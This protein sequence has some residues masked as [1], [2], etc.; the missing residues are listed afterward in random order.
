MKRNI[1]KVEADTADAEKKI[2]A[3]RSGLILLE[4]PKAPELAKAGEA[5]PV[6]AA[7]A[8]EMV[9]LRAFTSSQTDPEA[10]A[11][12]VPF[13]VRNKMTAADL[14]RR[15]LAA[16]YEPPAVAAREVKVEQPK[17]RK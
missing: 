11:R 9:A 5:Y 13:V 4:E 16:V 2:E 12:G 10:L 3:V 1:P 15:G 8:I 14:V 17:G 6:N 7:G